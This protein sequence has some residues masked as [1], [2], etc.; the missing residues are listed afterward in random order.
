[1]NDN[2][3]LFLIRWIVHIVYPSDNTKSIQPKQHVRSVDCYKENIA[4]RPAKMNMV[5]ILPILAFLLISERSFVLVKAHRVKRLV[6]S[7]EDTVNGKL[8]NIPIDY[9]QDEETENLA[10]QDLNEVTENIGSPRE[11]HIQIVQ[12]S[13]NSVTKVKTF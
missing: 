3:V 4:F 13:D 9:I 2:Q 11:T 8:A 7:D 12:R 6:A 10:K 1:M 5:P